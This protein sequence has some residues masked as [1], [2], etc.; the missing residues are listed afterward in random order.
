VEAAQPMSARALVGLTAFVV[1]LAVIVAIDRPPP[2][3]DPAAAQ[4]LFTDGEIGSIV[5][6]TLQAPGEPD[7]VL[8]R[9]PGA[10]AAGFSLTAPVGAPVDPAAVQDLLGTLSGLALRRELAAGDG[11]VAAGRGLVAGARRV[12]LELSDG[13]PLE[14]VVGAR[15]AGLGRTWM[16]R[17]D[18]RRAYL[19]DDYFA[20]ALVRGA[21][22]LRRRDLLP[23]GPDA[24]AHDP[25]VV[26]VGAKTLT[27]A[28]APATVV[29]G[30]GAAL[31]DAA[32]AEGLLRRLADLRATRFF[33]D[34]AAAGV[35]VGADR[36]GGATPEATIHLG[37]HRLAVYGPCPGADD[38]RAA[39][40]DVLGWVCVRA[41]LLPWLDE[42]V[43][44]PLTWVE[45]APLPLGPADARAVHLASV[46]RSVH[47]I[48]DGGVWRLGEG[49]GAAPVDDGAIGDWLHDV[50][51]YAGRAVTAPRVL[52]PPPGAAT[53][54]VSAMDRPDVVIWL[55]PGPGDDIR[56]RRPGEPVALLVHR[57]FAGYF[58][59]DPVVFRDRTVLSLSPSAI[60]E[61]EIDREDG[62]ERLTRG[63]S[64]DDWSLAVRARG[65]AVAA[66]AAAAVDPASAV[67]VSAAAAE[68]LRGA[69]ADLHGARVLAVAP[70]PEDGLSPPRR[71][72]AVVLDP[73]PT[74]PDAAP[75][76][77]TVELGERE[78]AGSCVVRKGGASPGPVMRVEDDVCAALWAPLAA[79]SPLGERDPRSAVAVRIGGK[80]YERLGPGWVGPDGTRLGDE[81]AEALL[82]LVTGLIEPPAVLG[83]GPVRPR[84]S[85]EIRWS[86]GTSTNLSLASP[87]YGATAGIV[88]FQLAAAVCTAWPTV[89]I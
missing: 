27:L 7:V 25:L 3:P 55:E 84:V 24:L 67:P 74:T 52:A 68:A 9:A 21:D 85:L 16:A 86:D 18:R 51:A 31:A 8:E 60:R 79:A 34:G 29:L 69:L 62:H 80:R 66:G 4:R 11:T 42:A 73:P 64:L 61:I 63:A 1:A 72:I 70:R 48:R 6:L 89:C 33:S 36:A 30:D 39:H 12:R 47:L 15:V 77:E 75:A 46:G 41:D 19:V 32:R 83:Y 82:A 13:P 35:V 71:T 76:R 50:T 22:D 57:S 20:R 87:A 23:L 58:V 59:P 78:I 43:S 26:T 14:L 81:R 38:E 49:D 5:R 2:P 56:V 65:A 53:L 40:G 45:R 28:G 88:R 54:T 37:P 10:P 44:D 17:G